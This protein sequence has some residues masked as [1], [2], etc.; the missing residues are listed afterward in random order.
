MHWMRRVNKYYKQNVKMKKIKLHK[1]NTT[2]TENS[3]QI[4][5]LFIGLQLPPL[6]SPIPNQQK[7]K[8]GN[9]KKREENKKP[10][11]LIANKQ[12]MKHNCV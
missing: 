1:F 11:S 4:P 2:L 7:S 3:C 9:K 6:P 10:T 5:Y 8:Y 12:Q